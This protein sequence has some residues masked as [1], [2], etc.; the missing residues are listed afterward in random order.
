[1]LLSVESFN[2]FQRELFRQLVT[3]LRYMFS[4]FHIWTNYF[5]FGRSADK[6]C[7]TGSCG[8][9]APGSLVE[10]QSLKWKT[11]LSNSRS[12][13]FFS[14]CNFKGSALNLPRTNRGLTLVESSE[15][16]GGA[17]GPSSFWKVLLRGVVG[18]GGKKIYFCALFHFYKSHIPRY[19]CIYGTIVKNFIH[20]INT[21]FHSPFEHL[22]FKITFNI[23]ILKVFAFHDKYLA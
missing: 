21:F 11:W 14:N 3:I 23:K 13:V 6:G 16:W 15:G 1:M 18:G 5:R 9:A 12:L 17:G 4:G 19:L 22:N 8:R 20:Q 7:W 10:I 2:W